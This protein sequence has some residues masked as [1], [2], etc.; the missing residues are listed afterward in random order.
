MS[1]VVDIKWPLVTFPTT[2][3]S[4]A[5]IVHTP[6]YIT[7]RTQTWLTTSFKSPLSFGLYVAWHSPVDLGEIFKNVMKSPKLLQS[8]TKAYQFILKSESPC[9]C[10]GG[11]GELGHRES[12]ATPSITVTWNIMTRCCRLTNQLYIIYCLMWPAYWAHV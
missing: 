9:S 2:T 3:G 10:R 8:Y 1:M 5:L 12:L 6:R 4:P 11:L 7:L